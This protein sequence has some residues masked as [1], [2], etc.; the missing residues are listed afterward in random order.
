M[1][2]VAASTAG[3]KHYGAFVSYLRV[4]T[5]TQGHS[6]LGLDAQRQAVADYLNGGRWSL[7]A[8][9]VEV[10]S[11][12]NDDRPKLA[13][14]LA[15]CRVHNATLVIAKLDRLSRDAHFLLGLQKAGV[16]FVAADMP[17]ANEMIVGIM[18]VV[19]QAERRMISARTKAALAAA[20]ARGTKLG[21]DRGHLAATAAKGQQASLAARRKAARQRAEDLAPILAELRAQ[22]VTSLTK[23]ADALND[24][25]VPAA[26]GGRW[27]PV[28]VGR[29]MAV[30][31]G[32]AVGK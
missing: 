26:R 6:A 24:R 7:I 29:L 18:A 22:G 10:E 11:G 23:I 4:S 13:E 16:K 19:A 31:A 9:Y 1:A 20:K 15:R 14:A 8:E 21:G 12:A 32:A 25:G 2:A 28:Q 30:R 3:K 27:T 5:K 17:E